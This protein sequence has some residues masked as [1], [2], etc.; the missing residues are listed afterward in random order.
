MYVCVCNLPR[1][2]LLL[3][4]ISYR[5]DEASLSTKLGRSF[6]SDVSCLLR[7]FGQ[8]KLLGSINRE[9]SYLLFPRRPGRD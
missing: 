3:S 9:L 8:I 1:R 6:S 2:Q 4:A 7:R 5:T